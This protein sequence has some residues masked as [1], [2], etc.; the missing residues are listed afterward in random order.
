MHPKYFLEISTELTKG[1]GGRGKA[2]QGRSKK[3]GAIN[4]STRQGS[5]DMV[6][7]N[8]SKDRESRGGGV[9]FFELLGRKKGGGGRVSETA[10]VNKY[11]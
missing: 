2:P 11:T 6:G 1:L 4:I 7:E 5:D 8:W 9:S 3:K 10:C